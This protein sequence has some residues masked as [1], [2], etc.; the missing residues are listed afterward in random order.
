VLGLMRLKLV[1]VQETMLPFVCL[2]IISS[3]HLYWKRPSKWNF[4][5][6]L[7]TQ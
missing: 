5:F 4:F 3:W 6:P 1:V 2:V 7:L